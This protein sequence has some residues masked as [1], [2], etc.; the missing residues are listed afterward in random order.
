MNSKRATTF[1]ENKTAD[2]FSQN[3]HIL[4]HPWLRTWSNWWI[5]LLF[6]CEM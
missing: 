5:H 6:E 4:D 3:A 1:V 2:D